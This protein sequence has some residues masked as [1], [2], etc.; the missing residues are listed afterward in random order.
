M[1]T[2]PILAPILALLS[3]RAFILSVITAIVDAGIAAVPSL[4]P[5]RDQL[6]TIVTGLAALLIVKMGVEDAAVK[7]GASRAYGSAPAAQVVRLER[8]SPPNWLPQ[9]PAPV[10]MANKAPTA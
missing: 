10:A 6:I 3:S 9:Q 4:L 1:I 7:F 8:L 2:S 5:L